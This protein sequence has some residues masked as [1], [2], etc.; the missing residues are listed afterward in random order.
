MDFQTSFGFVKTSFWVRKIYCADI[1]S[2]SG[3]M[4]WI[5]VQWGTVASFY[6]RQREEEC[7]Y[8]SCVNMIKLSWAD[9]SL[10][11]VQLSVHV[12]VTKRLYT[13]DTL[14]CGNHLLII[15]QTRV[16]LHPDLL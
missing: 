10:S 12:A 14:T 11:V 1:Y 5:L 15:K 2:R 3:E 9:H 13:D 6:S 4:D 8:S 7:Q 16:T